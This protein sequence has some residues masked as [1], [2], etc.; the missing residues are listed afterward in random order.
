MTQKYEYLFTPLKVGSMIMPN[1]ILSG[2]HGTRAYK[3]DQAPPEN[4][5]QY[6]EARAK[7]GAGCID[8][9]GLNV[10]PTSKFGPLPAVKDESKIDSFKRLTDAVHKHGT[11]IIV[12]LRDHTRH[13]SQLYGGWQKGPS[14]VHYHFGS[15]KFP[16]PTRTPH[17]LLPMK[18]EVPHELE[19]DEIQE[20][21]EA[22]GTVAGLM[23]K[24]GFDGA[25]LN[26]WC[27]NLNALF[28]S[29]MSNTR[30]DQYGG[31]LE[32]RMRFNHEVIQAIRSAV[33]KDFALGM[34]IDGDQM[35]DGAITL[36]DM[37]SIAQEYEATGEI[38]FFRV[39]APPFSSLCMNYPLG[40]MVYLAAGIKE[41]VKVPVIALCRINDPVQAD[42][43]LADG[44]ADIIQMTRGLICDPELPKK[45][46]E[47]R[48]EEI[49]R[50]IACNER[51]RSKPYPPALPVRCALNPEASREATFAIK[52][53]KT[54]KKIMVVGGGG[55]GL[56]AAR[57]AALG[58]QGHPL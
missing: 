22:F 1:R 40:S 27:M 43:I 13:S 56:E 36:D 53:A 52:P 30:G 37:K 16:V 14:P 49:R 39:G 20:Y 41:A 46:R 11:K 4:V 44:H 42:K 5:I 7:G 6:Y 57:V 35:V 28:L 18:T 23:K 8:V 9:S 38:D 25:D 3:E 2:A 17:E 33:G 15:R 12:Q 26:S 31:S 29:Q 34:S 32:N 21:I 19:L 55:A 47:G 58:A 24:A 10:A 45:A 54:K 51:C 48:L 50:C